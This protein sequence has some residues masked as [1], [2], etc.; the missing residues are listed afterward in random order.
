MKKILFIIITFFVFNINCYAM[1]NSVTKYYKTSY[2]Y[3]I[4]VTEEIK[5]EEYDNSEYNLLS[6]DYTE[7]DYKKATL[8]IIDNI[9]SLI[10][11]WKKE[12]RVKSYDIISL[13]TKNT[14]IR[15]GTISGSQTAVSGT[16]K[17]TY[18]YNSDIK[19]TKL[20]SQGC[21]ISMNLADN[22]QKYTLRLSA[23]LN[24]TSNIEIISS[25]RHAVKNITLNTSQKYSLNNGNIN[26][27]TTALNSN[28]DSQI[29]LKITA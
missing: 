3:D 1:E 21:G 7:T 29:S 15:K 28:Y 8:K 10:I 25:Y 6:S 26:F 12:P 11:E 22:A 5:K 19:N 2:L 13:Y 24:N 14:S 18:T 16:D 17:K 27:S 9:A 23:D 20:F 4:P